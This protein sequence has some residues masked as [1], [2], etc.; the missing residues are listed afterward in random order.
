MP[1]LKTA[2]ILGLLSAVSPFAIDMYLP[3][4]PEIG[5]DLSTTVSGTQMTVTAYFLSFGLALR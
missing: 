1:S 3:A 2:L 5:R 4:M